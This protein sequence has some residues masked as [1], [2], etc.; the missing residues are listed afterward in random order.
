M[1]NS[2]NTNVAKEFGV[3][4]A[5][6][7]QHL[8][9]WSFKNLANNRHIHDGLC[10]SYDTLNALCDTFPYFSLRQI[11]TIID[12]AVDL[13]L[14]KKC[15]YN[16][17]G[18]DRTMWYALT[19]DAMKFYPE[20]MQEKYLLNLIKSE[21]TQDP[22]SVLICQKW[23]MHL[24]E[25]TNRFDQIDTPIPT[26]ITTNKTTNIYTCDPT[27]CAG[28]SEVITKELKEPS[29]K[30]E[31]GITELLAENPHEI[32]EPM[33]EDF[34]EVRRSKKARV[35]ATAWRRV[36]NTLLEI[37]GKLNI[38]PIYAFE[39]MVA[40]AWQS[41]QVKYFMDKTISNGEPGFMRYAN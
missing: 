36:N 13:N 15:N 25:L 39:T 27:M 34:L 4:I 18:Y 22:A 16:K 1:I 35:T 41:I 30:L 29:K 33:L 7:I 19:P 20:L 10:W 12:N 9:Q 23:Q 26:N 28:T 3:N 32:P 40:N 37:K 38:T 14:I 17:A 8:S 6:F 31:Y 11:R 5:I 21:N 24:S 2:F